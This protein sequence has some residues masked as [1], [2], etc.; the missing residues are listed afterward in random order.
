[1]DVLLRC[2]FIGL[3]GVKPGEGD[4]VYVRAIWGNWKTR[5]H[6][7]EGAGIG[8]EG[9]AADVRWGGFRGLLDV[10]SELT[11]GLEI[12]FEE[13]CL[14][15]RVVDDDVVAEGAV[16]IDGAG[17]LLVDGEHHARRCRRGGSHGSRSRVLGRRV[18]DF[19]I[20]RTVGCLE[21]KADDL[22]VVLVIGF[23]H[24]KYKVHDPIVRTTRIRIFLN[25][26]G[27]LY[28]IIIIS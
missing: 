4:G 12:I 25:K 9:V 13:L 14:A 23:G 15:L 10:A 6:D 8:L 2:L 5:F 17:L 11:Y 20:G 7:S 16:E 24:A 26:H 18:G 19:G 3:E 28:I 22:D 21:S 27:Y 1:M